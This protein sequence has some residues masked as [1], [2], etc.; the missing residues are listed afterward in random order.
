MEPRQC[1]RWMFLFNKPTKPQ[2]HP[3]IKH[4]CEVN[5]YH[6]HKGKV[7]FTLL[8]FPPTEESQTPARLSYPPIDERLFPELQE[9]QRSPPSLHSPLLDTHDLLCQEEL[10]EIDLSSVDDQKDSPDRS[11]LP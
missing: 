1:L 5:G 2:I 11:S 10:K 3:L 9:L 4:L 6:R 8:D 7:F